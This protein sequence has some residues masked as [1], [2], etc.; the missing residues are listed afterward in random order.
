MRIFFLLSWYKD[1]NDSVGGTFFLEQAKAIKNLGHEVILLSAKVKRIKKLFSTESK[2]IGYSFWNDDGIDVLQYNSY[3]WVPKLKISAFFFRT[4]AFF[5]L[6]NKAEKKYGKPDILHAHSCLWAGTAGAVIKRIKKTPLV[7]TEHSSA[8]YFNKISNNDL[9]WARFGFNKSNK[10]IFVSRSLQTTVEKSLSQKVDGEIIPNIINTE[11][12]NCMNTL[13]NGELPFIF[14]S[15]AGLIRKKNVD[16]LIEAFSYFH[17]EIANSQLIIV[18]DGPEKESLMQIVDE[19]KLRNQI[20]FIGSVKN[21]EIINY[22]SQCHVF[23]LLSDYETFGVAYIE[24]L[25]CGRPVIA[26]NN[27]GP[28][29]FINCNNGILVEPKNIKN[30]VEAM[31]EL[32]FKYDLYDSATI[33]KEI[34]KK[35][36]KDKIAS[37]LIEIYKEL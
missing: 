5:S 9:Q 29:E 22:I 36:S 8:Y 3:I 37:K 16:L 30:V 18:G 20:V 35:F 25:S 13:V 31:K 15:V 33:R 26:T 2:K 23:I 32:Y 11:H 21:Y 19:K 10:N 1:K 28:T 12:F 24:A 34:V 4:L 17:Q 14:L 6:V 27:G 7:I